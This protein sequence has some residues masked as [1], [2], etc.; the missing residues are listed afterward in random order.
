M[1]IIYTIV[2]VQENKKCAKEQKMFYKSKVKV[3][4]GPMQWGQIIFF[5]AYYGIGLHCVWPCGALCRVTL[6]GL[7]Y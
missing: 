1:N 4:K 5:V 6:C 3:D 7:V 2:H